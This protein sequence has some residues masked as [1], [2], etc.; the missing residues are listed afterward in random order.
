MEKFFRLDAAVKYIHS[1][2][3]HTVTDTLTTVVSLS[4]TAKLVVLQF[5]LRNWYIFS[6]SQEASF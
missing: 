6:C 4:D 1:D 5:C 2:Q 3:A